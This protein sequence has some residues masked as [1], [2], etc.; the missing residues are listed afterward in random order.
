MMDLILEL[1]E[2][3]PSWA[4]GLAALMLAAML[5]RVIRRVRRRHDPRYEI[6]NFLRGTDDPGAEND[7]RF[8]G[9]WTEIHPLPQRINKD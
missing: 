7:S 5:Y 9:N 6:P 2:A 8:K 4:A 3:V 1:V